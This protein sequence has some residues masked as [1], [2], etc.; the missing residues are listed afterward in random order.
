[1]RFA[2]IPVSIL[3]FAGIASA[4]NLNPK[5]LTKLQPMQAFQLAGPHFQD[6]VTI[7]NKEYIR[8]TILPGPYVSAYKDSAGT[9]YLGGDD[10]MEF[11][12]HRTE[13]GADVETLKFF[14][15]CG[16]YLP[17]DTSQ[18]VRLFFVTGTLGRGNPQ[19]P[20]L[21]PHTTLNR[22]QAAMVSGV[23]AP[24]AHAGAALGGVL[25]NAMIRAS[26]GKFRFIRPAGPG[27]P[28]DR[29]SLT[30]MPL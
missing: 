20:Q 13:T 6:E 28:F 16:F 4:A 27:K 10:C 12:V 22:A 25:V 24:A 7:R 30:E 18:D 14:Y 8:H 1:M 9:Y 29:S 17:D 3:L 23:P 26:Q 19:A 2:F 15:D 21:T 11:S 5:K